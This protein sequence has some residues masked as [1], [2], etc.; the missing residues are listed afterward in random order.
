MKIYAHLSEAD[1]LFLVL[2]LEF[3]RISSI[4]LHYT[5]I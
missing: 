3:V 1:K 2:S 4:V 5:M